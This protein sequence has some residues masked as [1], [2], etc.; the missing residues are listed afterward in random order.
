MGR[1]APKD[2]PVTA[3][4]HRDRDSFW[5]HKTGRPDRYPP[6]AVLKVER[7]RL[8]AADQHR[9]TAFG[10]DPKVWI[11]GAAELPDEGTLRELCRRFRQVQGGIH[12]GP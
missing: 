4:V 6:L 1:N 9:R 12:R 3:V 7:G 5:N 8:I 11:K 10:F 2:L